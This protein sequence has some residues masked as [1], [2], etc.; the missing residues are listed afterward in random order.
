MEN[1]EKSQAERLGWHKPTIH[2]L[3][4]SLDTQSGLTLSASDVMDAFGGP[5]QSVVDT[6][7][8]DFA[9]G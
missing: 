1:L 9:T 7:N 3:L 8:S 5:Q 4:V 6:I 2:R